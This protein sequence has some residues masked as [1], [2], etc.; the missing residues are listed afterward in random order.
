MSVLHPNSLFALS[1][2]VCFI[3]AIGC[4]RDL[5][6]T[7]GVSPNATPAE[8]LDFHVPAFDAL[9]TVQLLGK[10]MRPIENATLLLELNDLLTNQ[11]RVIQSNDF[12]G[13]AWTFGVEGISD[14]ESARLWIYEKDAGLAAFGL[15]HGELRISHKPLRF[16]VVPD[17]ND[18][19]RLTFQFLDPSGKPLRSLRVGVARMFPDGGGV[20]ATVPNA[21]WETCR[22]VTDANGWATLR[23]ANGASV[24][25]V[26]SES[27]RY[28]RQTIPLRKSN[29]HALKHARTGIV[30][31][32]LDESVA[33]VDVHELVLNST[34]DLGVSGSWS[35]AEPQPGEYEIK[36]PSGDLFL[37]SFSD[38]R[39]GLLVS[40]TAHPYVVPEGGKL[41]VAITGT[42]GCIVSGRLVSS[43]GIVKKPIT[44]AHVSIYVTDSIQRGHSMVTNERGEFS[45]RLQPGEFTISSAVRFPGKTSLF[46]KDSIN[47][48]VTA[49]EQELDVG[50]LTLPC[51]FTLRGKV[52]DADGK[53]LIF[54]QVSCSQAGKVIG[55]GKTDTE[56]K[57]TAILTSGEIEEFSIWPNE[58]HG[59]FEATVTQDSPLTL[60][61]R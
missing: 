55:G 32:L 25:D 19:D 36:L 50:T 27:V 54:A 18:S 56:G 57:F 30:R 3:S 60:R 28:G 6:P 34:N 9:F 35:I 42:E 47:G 4:Q 59:R 44:G 23:V 26:Q 5:A 8:T 12:D 15:K 17:A 41:E 52:V 22:E 38:N 14:S 21:L 7:P 24:T 46:M 31:L 48:I 40:R 37:N 11:S 53:P 2:C 58:I 1:T 13:N 61:V 29:P 39:Q 51:L 16:A 45:T 10:G 43:D 33:D 20:A 49:S